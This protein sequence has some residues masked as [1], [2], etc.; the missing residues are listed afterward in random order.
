MIIACD[1]LVTFTHLCTRMARLG[2]RRSLDRNN[3]SR[4]ASGLSTFRKKLQLANEH[5]GPPRLQHH[6]QFLGGRAPPVG[7]DDGRGLSQWL[8]SKY[9]HCFLGYARPMLPLRRGAR[10]RDPSRGVRNLVRQRSRR[11]EGERAYTRIFLLA[12]RIT[13]FIYNVTAWGDYTGKALA[14]RVATNRHG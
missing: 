4:P 11:R 13:I 7:M 8:R 6:S 9:R 1:F 5:G 3:L 14:F 12:R 2:S 10:P